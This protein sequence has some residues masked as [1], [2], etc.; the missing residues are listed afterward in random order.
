MRHISGFVHSIDFPSSYSSSLFPFGGSN[1][2]KKNI[3]GSGPVKSNP[4]DDT[5]KLQN[6]LVNASL[7]FSSF[8]CFQLI[9]QR[10]FGLLRLHGGIPNTLISPIGSITT[11][12]SILLSQKFETRI[13]QELNP[14]IGRDNNDKIL[15]PRDQFRKD[16]K[17]FL[18]SLCSFIVLEQGAFR[19]AFPSSVIS[20]G[21]FAN[22]G[23]MNKRSVPATSELTTASQRAAI[24][25]FGR[26]F[27]CHQCGSRQLLSRDIFIADH[28]PPTKIANEMS[29]VWW[30]RLFNVK[31]TQRLWPQCQSCYSIQGMA[32]RNNLHALVY[33]NVIRR[34][35][36]A[37]IL[38]YALLQSKIVDEDLDKFLGPFA[39]KIYSYW[40]RIPW[41]KST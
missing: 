11:A 40:K 22:I 13:R 19:T 39:D 17:R 25:S 4:D 30:R 34:H 41:P 20:L 28:M 18:L 29:K 33:H 2:P 8:Y 37:P 3:F 6:H 38:S 7:L 31:V 12:A 27:G 10:C 23:N 36:F 5:L 21:I 1:S 32:V 14:Y 16:F 35:H 24:Q 26:R 15:L 9:A